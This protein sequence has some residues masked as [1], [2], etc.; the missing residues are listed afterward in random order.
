[1]HVHEEL[2]LETRLMKI[3]LRGIPMGGAG[4]QKEGFFL[5]HI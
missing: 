1:M 3:K 4:M 5:S 2:N